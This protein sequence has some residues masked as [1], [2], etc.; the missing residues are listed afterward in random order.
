MRQIIDTILHILI[1]ITILSVLLML[2]YKL[3]HT[4]AFPWAVVILLASIILGVGS[5]FFLPPSWTSSAPST[6]QNPVVQKWAFS[7]GGS[8]RSSPTVVN[9]V[10][11]IGSSDHK[12]YALDANTGQRKWAFLAGDSVETTPTVV[13]GVLYVGCNDHQVYALDARTGQQKWVFPTGSFVRSS[14]IVVDGVLY[15]GSQDNKIYAL[16][17]SQSS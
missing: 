11:Y 12:V 2:A 5:G 7:T 14:P 3:R 17:L 13:D 15:V 4:R 1:I 6:E 16:T 8:V 9:G 10:L